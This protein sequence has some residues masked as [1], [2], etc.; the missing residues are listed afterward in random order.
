[1]II[2]MIII[3]TIIII[4]IITKKNYLHQIGYVYSHARQIF[5]KSLK[6]LTK[7]YISSIFPLY[8]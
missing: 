2:I 7:P 1:M 3:I 8:M 6:F 4:I 5:K